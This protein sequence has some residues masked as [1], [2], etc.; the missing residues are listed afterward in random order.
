MI[1]IPYQTHFLSDYHTDK[2]LNI[3][4]KLPS[5]KKIIY[6][7]LGRCGYRHIRLWQLFI[8]N[9]GNTY[10]R[11]SP[12][13]Q[14]TEILAS[15]IKHINIVTHRKHSNQHFTHKNYFAAND[16]HSVTANMNPVSYRFDLQTGPWR[17]R[18]RS[19]KM[20]EYGYTYGFQN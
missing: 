19:S 16:V 3:Q 1:W 11:C 5:K 18:N 13:R 10:R 20:I 2:R 9:S 17:S 12:L 7:P 15:S 14:I 6:G 8:K 4:Q